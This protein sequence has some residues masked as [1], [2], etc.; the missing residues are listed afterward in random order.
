MPGYLLHEGATVLCSHAGQAV[1]TVTDPR[2]TV[3]GQAVVTQATLDTV[4]GCALPPPPAANGPCL[5][6][7]WVTAATRVTAGGQP[8]LLTDSQADLRPTGTPLQV[9]LTQFRVKGA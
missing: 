9:V 1:P 5:T 8:V 3:S 4:A 7:S 6:A 2:V